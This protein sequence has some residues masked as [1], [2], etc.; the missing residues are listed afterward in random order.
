VLSERR[1]HG[2]ASR[3]APGRTDLVHQALDPVVVAGPWLLAGWGA[4]K[5]ARALVRAV[6][7]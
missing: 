1:R 7:R 5:G 4:T 6:R 2:L 3:R